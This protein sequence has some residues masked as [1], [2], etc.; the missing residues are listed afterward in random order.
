VDR[1]EEVDRPRER[2]DR[3]DVQRE[4]E[5]VGTGA[6]GLHRERRVDRPAGVG[7]SARGEEAR[8]ERDAAEE[9]RPVG[10]CVQAREGHVARADHQR[11]EEVPEAGQDRHD[12]EEDHRDAVDREELVVVLAR[13]EVLVRRRKLRTDEERE[14]PAGHEE[15]ERRRDVEDPDALVVDGREPA[16][17]PPVLPRDRVGVALGSNR[18]STLPPG[19]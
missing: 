17:E 1:G 7:R 2:G 16:H 19:P 10:E 13:D 5:Q 6:V 11:N 3:K 18:H 9:E 15:D 12:D 8:V 14:D 4:D